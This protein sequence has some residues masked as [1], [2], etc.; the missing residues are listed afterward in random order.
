MPDNGEYI[1][2]NIGFSSAEKPLL[3]LQ[4]GETFVDFYPIGESFTLTF[5]TTERHCTGWRDI[6]TE[7][8]FVCPTG[9]TVEVKYEQCS[10]CQKRTGFNPAFYHSSSV[11]PQQETRNQ[12]PHLLYLAHFGPG[13]IKAGISHAQRKN[14]RLLEQGA[15][16]AIILDTFPSATIARQY[17][18]KI[19][20]MPGIVETVQQRKKSELI[21]KPYDKDNGAKELLATKEIA[22]S[23]L[24][25]TFSGHTPVHLDGLYFPTPTVALADAYDTSDSS[26]ISGKCIGVLGSVLFCEQG[27]ELTYL[28]LKKYV[29]YK[30]AFDRSVKDIA[31]PARQTSLF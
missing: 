30:V 28:P 15:R 1:F 13:V 20:A 26:A 16:S 23:K 11:S 3:L 2:T 6:T 29:G 18:A 17:E 5:D 12:E 27:D 31:L 22:E 9:N 10:A 7:E 24:G 19:A 21:L 4:S 14:S 8:R 25:I